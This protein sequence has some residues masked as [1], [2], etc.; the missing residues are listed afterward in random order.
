MRVEKREVQAGAAAD[1]AAREAA[2][3]TKA[4]TRTAEF[5]GLSSA[6]LARTIGL[7]EASVSR[8]RS[9]RYELSPGTK[10]FEL[11]VLLVR[12]YRALDS[13]MGDDQASRGWLRARNVALEGRPLD[14]IQ[15]VAGLVNVIQYL[16]SRRARV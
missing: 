2:V 11:A 8:L 16:D 12:L 3:L 10:P 6:E 15:T 4:T 1:H 13:L 9:G 14:M 7:S 5:L